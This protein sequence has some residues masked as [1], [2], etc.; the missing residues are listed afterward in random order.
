MQSSSNENELPLSELRF[1]VLL[2][3]EETNRLF[4]LG[5]C[6]LREHMRDPRCPFVTRVGER[7]QLII[8]SKLE[9]Y[10]LDHRYF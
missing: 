6:N 1:K 4:G 5:I 7:K 9:E 8:R 3:V 2:T 10:I